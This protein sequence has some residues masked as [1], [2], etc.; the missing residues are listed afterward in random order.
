MTKIAVIGLGIM[1][2]GIASNFLKQGDDVTVWN[3]TKQKAD[4]LVA[5]GAHVAG[6][7]KA[8]AEAADIVFEVTANDESSREVW[9]GDDGILAAGDRP[10]ALI[11]CATLSIA[12][13]DELAQKAQSN[14]HD[15][16]DMAMTG[17]RQGAES[18]QLVLLVGGDKV[19]LDKLEPVLQHIAA[20]VKYFGPAGS[21]MRYKLI[22]NMVQAIHIAALGEALRLA[23]AAGLDEKVVGD[24]L[25]ER[26]G[27][28]TTNLAWRDYQVDPQPINF[29]VE[30]IHKDLTYAKRLE[31]GSPS[32]LLDE[33]LRQ[34]DKA[35]AAGL[36]SADWT[37]IN[38]L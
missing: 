28:T 30:W 7:P 1:G 33:V 2:H 16:F 21:G 8:A 11:T 6:S 27:G 19:K 14:T 29:S 17:G 9:L 25:N 4:D 20:T 26:P 36:S 35:M 24:A 3:R 32:P 34:Y 5:V 10:R 37:K 12:W 13:V 38:K 31:G 22:L 15:F 18:G 23:K